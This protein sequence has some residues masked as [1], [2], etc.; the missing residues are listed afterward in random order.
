M[1]DD[2]VP[3]APAEDDASC[4]G[5][6]DDCDGATDE[7]WAEAS[8]TC[9]VGACAATG[10]TACKTGQV[11]DT[12]APAQGAGSDGDCDGVDDDCD[13]QTDEDFTAS[14]TTCGVGACAA[15]G[16]TK[17][18]GGA[19]VDTCVAGTAAASDGDCDGVDDDCSGQADE[20]Y[21]PLATSC[22][23]GG[24]KSSGATSCF[25]GAVVDSCTAGSPAPADASCNGKDDDC[26]GGTDEDYAPS[27]TS[28]GVGVCAAAGQLLCSAGA[29]V[30]TCSA[31]GG[32]SVDASCN[33]KD[34]DCDG[35]TDEDYP[36]GQSACGVGACLA[37]GTLTCQEGAVVDSCTAGAAAPD[38]A[39][40]DGVDD[41]CDGKTDEDYA[42]GSTT[43]GE[44]ACQAQ[45]QLVCSGGVVVDTC[46]EAGGSTTD[47]TCNGVDDD[48]DGQ[49]D[50]E[51]A[52][53]GTECGVGPCQATGQL[54]CQG[55]QKIDTCA[56]GQAA[57]SDTSCN[58]VD[59]DCDGGTDEDYVSVGLSCG[60]GA[61]AASGVRHCIGGKEIDQCT[62]QQPNC[63][64]KQCGADGCGGSCGQC[65]QGLEC[66]PAG[67]CQ[68]VPQCG[69]QQC[70]GDGCGGSCGTCTVDLPCQ[71]PQCL[72][73]QCGV[74]VEAGWCV[75]NGTCYQ[76]GGGPS[77]CLVCD[78][79]ANPWGWTAL[80]AGA[81]CGDDGSPCTED[82]CD[83]EGK[84]VHE[85]GN[86]YLGCDDGSSATVG[87]WC[88]SG[89][90]LGFS[91][92][93][94]DPLGQ[95]ADA[96]VAGSRSGLGGAHAIFTGYGG[97]GAYL[98]R[99]PGGTSGSLVGVGGGTGYY[100]LTEELLVNGSFLWEEVGGK[101]TNAYD[102][103]SIRKAWP[104]GDIEFQPYWMALARY[105][106][107]GMFGDHQTF[108]AGRSAGDGQ[109]VVRACTVPAGLCLFPG[110]AW[111][112][113]SQSAGNATTEYPVGA[114]YY[115]DQPVIGSNYSSASSPTFIDLLRYDEGQQAWYYDTN[116]EQSAGGRVLRAFGAVSGTD[117]S[118]A[119]H[120]WLVGAGTNGLLYVSDLQA[121]SPVT[122][123]SFGQQA[124]T[125]FTALTAFDDRVFVVG[126]YLD[127]SGSHF[128]LAHAPIDGALASGA[129][130]S[131]HALASLAGGV[132][133]YLPGTMA[134]VV[135]DGDQLFLFGGWY[136]AASGGTRRTVWHWA[137]GAD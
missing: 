70:G 125:E 96:Y 50:E 106:Q 80:K 25:G 91:W 65:D 58:G 4:N 61:C 23:I 18:V 83:G 100:S 26:D 102:D 78:W 88:H 14:S 31:G 38:D 10:V 56:P 72:E 41:D 49:T 62:P 29:Q 3:K 114:A 85:A 16:T 132:T 66:D 119:S 6:D 64:N 130:W 133:G 110:C 135:G 63:G 68:C 20:D 105:W 109:L 79:Q 121:T 2:C 34:D 37:S 17:C 1:V 11:I 45:G 71:V 9:G 39:D 7:D 115:G 35:G 44:G 32:S 103:L 36:V 73:G 12:C 51:Y 101:W 111:E 128:V 117:A 116:L 94:E 59:D 137:K 33:G 8:T 30:D 123:P 118:G 43:C 127:S 52:P 42:G 13:G 27:A 82:V 75:I 113:S 84:C 22:G 81:S 99:Y 86:D 126:E 131:V 89:S 97:E 92:K 5:V 47:T 67:Q 77:D 60:E 98:Q 108:G 95:K 76:S 53:P 24:C 120:Q 69:G 87:D 74:A 107:P 122:I 28:C 136:S 112:C 129:S 48:C 104:S 15:Q 40:C 124:A 90:C 93:S 55:G 57:P 19:V 21:V 134:A 46:A 54:V